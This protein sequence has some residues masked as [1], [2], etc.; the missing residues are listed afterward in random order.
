MLAA[1]RFSSKC[2]SYCTLQHNLHLLDFSSVKDLQ[3]CYWVEFP[4]TRKEFK[5]LVYIFFSHLTLLFGL[6]DDSAQITHEKPMLIFYFWHIQE[7]ALWQVSLG[8]LFP[9]DFY[10]HFVEARGLNKWWSFKM[11][12]WPKISTSS[13]FPLLLRRSVKLLWVHYHVVQVLLSSLPTNF[14]CGAI[15]AKRVFT[16]ISNS[17]FPITQRIHLNFQS[18]YS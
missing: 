1:K 3:L 12:V 6:A 4:G 10:L 14:S 9:E 7:E 11:F 8:R 13:E 16:R 18:S 15:F 17:E 2:W 5:L